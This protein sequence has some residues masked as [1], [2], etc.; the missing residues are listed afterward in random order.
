MMRAYR[1]RLL[2]KLIKVEVR[3][4]SRLL[5]EYRDRYSQSQTAYKDD[6]F[7]QYLSALLYSDDGREDD[8]RISLEAAQKAY[9]DYGNIYATATPNFDIN[10][11][12]PN[13]GELIFFH[14]NGVAARKVS[15]SMQVAW[16]EAVA[17]VNAT[18]N[19]EAQSGQAINA[20]RAGLTGQ[21]I[22]ISYPAFEQDPF[23]IVD[24]EL[25]SGDRTAKT[26][27]VENISAL[28]QADFSERQAAIKLRAIARATIK[29]IIAKAAT[30]EAKKKYGRDSWQALLTQATSAAV[31]AATEVAD[32]RSWSTLPAQIRLAR[33][34]L[35]S[36]MHQIS[37]RYKD[38]N[39]KVIQTKMF[40]V[41]ITKGQ[42]SYLHDRTAL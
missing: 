12:S 10:S 15:R 5:Q 33:L 19:D 11:F 23:Q 2:K 3:K 21:A 6:A 40:T 39:G 1:L 8:A 30:D 28:A 36:G 29:F 31:A 9:K 41:T 38:A 16:N 13:S 14:Y 24:S 25:E 34:A 27:V 7:G 4:M 17:A 32:T 35:P 26:I 22:T 42:R 37:V 20:L 18:K